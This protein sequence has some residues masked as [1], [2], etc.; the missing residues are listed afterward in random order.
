[1]PTAWPRLVQ[2]GKDHRQPRRSM[3]CVGAGIQVGGDHGQVIS[4]GAA[5]SDQHHLDGPGAEDRVPQAGNGGGADGGERANDGAVATGANQASSVISD[6][7]TGSVA[8]GSTGGNAP[9]F[10][11]RDASPHQAR[12]HR[13]SHPHQMPA[14]RAR[15]GP[16]QTLTQQPASPKL[17]KSRHHATHC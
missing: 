12:S 7:G 14:P 11:P 4:G 8:F 15:T 9:R 2:R 16:A 1:M 10:T 5:V 6:G 17:R 3:T 13:V